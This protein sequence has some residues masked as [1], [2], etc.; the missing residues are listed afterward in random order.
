MTDGAFF[1]F[2]DSIQ[3]SGEEKK[4]KE[5]HENKRQMLQLKLENK[6]F[7]AFSAKMK[8]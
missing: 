5:I 8:A 3:I 1:C 6:G 4:R 7:E 2:K